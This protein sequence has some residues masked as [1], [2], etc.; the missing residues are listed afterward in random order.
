[1]P[2]R[3]RPAAV[4]VTCVTAFLLLVGCIP[5]SLPSVPEDAIERVEGDRV[6]I[7]AR[8]EYSNPTEE[9]LY[10]YLM[11]EVTG[12]E[13]YLDAVA[14]TL[15]QNGWEIVSVK[16]SPDNRV[17]ARMPDTAR[18]SLFDYHDYMDETRSSEPRRTF[19]QVPTS[20][21]RGYFVAILTPI[22]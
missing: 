6:A 2:V 15:E 22:W 11:L 1:M 3:W 17:S 21:D 16:P 8:A 4:I 13:P 10:T 20:D 19:A 14:S 12:Q 5:L 18:L 9:W 7:V